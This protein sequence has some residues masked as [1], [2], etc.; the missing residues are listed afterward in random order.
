MNEVIALI[1][2]NEQSKWLITPLPAPSQAKMSATGRFVVSIQFAKY[3]AFCPSNTACFAARYMPMGIEPAI[4]P[5]PPADAEG[6][7]AVVHF[8]GMGSQRRLEETSRMVDAL[9]KLQRKSNATSAPLGK[10]LEIKPRLEQRRDGQP[11]NESYIRAYWRHPT[12]LKA[13]GKTIRFYEVYWAPLMAE[14]TSVRRTLL[15]L[16]GL[17][18]R[19]LQTGST[20]WR[21]RQRLRRATLLELNQSSFWT[22]INANDQDI[23]TLLLRYNDFEGLNALE[24]YPDGSFKNFLAFV[25]NQDG[26]EA[27]QLLDPAG[28]ARMVALA[29]VWRRR[30][31]LTEARTFFLLITF[32]LTIGL[33]VGAF[34]WACSTIIAYL[35]QSAASWEAAA[36]FLPLIGDQSKV[37]GILF[38][39]TLSLI[40]IVRFITDALGDV[41]AWS[42]FAETNEKHRVRKAVLACGTGLLTHILAD[43]KCERVVVTAHSLGT[44]IANDTLLALARSNRASNER[45]R[46]RGDPALG[47]VDLKRIEHLVTF[48]SPI[49]KIEYFF[50]SSRSQSHRYRRVTEDLRGD[51]GEEP[52]LANTKPHIH[53]INVWDDGDLVSGP[54]TSPASAARN[55]NLVDN[56]HMQGFAFPNPVSAHIRY[57]R[58][59]PFVAMLFGII[60]HREKSFPGMTV[61]QKRAKTYGPLI[62]GPGQK[63]GARRWA[64]LL[65][66]ALP[67]VLAITLLL[68]QF[69]HIPPIFGLTLA[70]LIA[71]ILVVALV[72]SI[73]RGPLKPL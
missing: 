20:P 5:T 22:G 42:T 30:Y 8:H 71:S 58:Y 1:L 15:W 9:D 35:F 26:V 24:T 64:H 16:L 3:P 53:W 36:S 31:R 6:Y 44:A 69:A 13:K 29:H 45:Y 4:K 34:F 51:I 50:E 17:T 21:E 49:D 54:L 46:M 2:Q 47:G 60:V 39:A 43:G 55:R 10:L 72:R 18:L 67:W 62:V 19:P 25:R 63:P 68:H 28:V 37:T 27:E 7:I 11:G 33:A 61:A 73:L 48:G 12:D 40:G 56:V 32:L 41:E 52:Y 59:H 23:E 38:V 65:A 66:L 70:A 14:G 57:I